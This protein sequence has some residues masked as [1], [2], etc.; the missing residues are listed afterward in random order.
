MAATQ[1]VICNVKIL[2]VRS[3]TSGIWQARSVNMFDSLSHCAVAKPWLKVDPVPNLILAYYNFVY[4]K[5]LV[6]DDHIAVE[7]MLINHIS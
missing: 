1:Y 6:Q 4:P 3:R 7:S 5:A 2:L